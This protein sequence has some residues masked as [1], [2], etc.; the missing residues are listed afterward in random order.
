VIIVLFMNHSSW[1]KYSMG[2]VGCRTTSLCH[3]GMVYLHYVL[4]NWHLMYI[5]VL[6][7]YITGVRWW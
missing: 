7:M 6:H 3:W 2:K 1:R 4:L 5:S